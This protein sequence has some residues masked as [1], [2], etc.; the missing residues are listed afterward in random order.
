M[1]AYI[2]ITYTRIGVE[3]MFTNW[4]K[5]KPNL[6]DKEGVKTCVIMKKAEDNLRD[7]LKW[8]DVNCADEHSFICEYGH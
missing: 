5:T 7:V 6:E 8:E 3:V 4:A 2:L 1:N